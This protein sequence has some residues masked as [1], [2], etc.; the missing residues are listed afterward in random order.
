MSALMLSFLAIFAVIA[1]LSAYAVVVNGWRLFRSDGRL[2][3]LEALRGQ[4]LPPP[5][6]ETELAARDAARATR[7]CLSCGAQGRC[8]ELLAAR[9]WKALRGICPNNAYIDS[10]RTPD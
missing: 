6:F 9:D 1:A 4:G 8:D 2:R 7:R 5:S 10:L 3:L